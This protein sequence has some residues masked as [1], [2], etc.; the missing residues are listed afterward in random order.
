M[1]LRKGV[2]EIY[3][4]FTG[5]HPCQSAISNKYL[6]FTLVVKFGFLLIHI[7]QFWCWAIFPAVT[8]ISTS[9]TCVIRLS[10]SDGGMAV[11]AYR[12]VSE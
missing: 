9:E 1:L 5:E 6:K 4:K 12:V 2:L 10:E 8:C 11:S 7:A 3:S